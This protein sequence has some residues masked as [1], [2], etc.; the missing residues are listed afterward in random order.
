MVQFKVGKDSMKDI[1]MARGSSRI[2]RSHGRV[3]GESPERGWIVVCDGCLSFK[4]KVR[5]GDPDRRPRLPSAYTILRLN[6]RLGA[7]R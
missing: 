6:T 4:F 3:W 1:K 5:V 2:Q 7:L